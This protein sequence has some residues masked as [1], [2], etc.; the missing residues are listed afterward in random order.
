MKV[1]KD[2]T[3][4]LDSFDLV[5]VIGQG[6]FAMIVLVRKRDSQRYMALKI[7]KKTM[8]VGRHQTEYVLAERDALQCVKS[9][10]VTSRLYSFQT[11]SK[12]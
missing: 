5:Q 1:E 9:P 6:V 3:I 12:L 2:Q 4:S 10:F 7:Y 11:Q 8:I